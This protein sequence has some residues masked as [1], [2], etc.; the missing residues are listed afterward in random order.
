MHMLTRKDAEKAMEAV[1]GTT[2]FGEDN[3]K[4]VVPEGEERKGGREVA[5]DW[6]LSRDKWE[7]EKAEEAEVEPE[8]AAEEDVEEEEEEAAE[9][10]EDAEME[11][12]TIL[13]PMGDDE[14]SEE[15]EAVTPALPPPSEQTTLFVRNLSFEVTE[16]QLRTLCVYTSSFCLACA[17]LMYLCTS[18]SAVSEPTVPF[19]TL[20]SPWTRRPTDLEEPDSS[21]S[22]RRRTRRRRLRRPACSRPRWEERVST[23][24]P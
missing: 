2:V 12:G 5:V 14:E 16:D 22:G 9:S 3:F 13:A 10:G 15:D 23:L 20:E 24:F 11:D 18:L 1:N 21:A 7:K 8:V 4:A 19:D 6:A 17:R